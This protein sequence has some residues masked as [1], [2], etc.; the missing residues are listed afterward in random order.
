MEGRGVLCVSPRL[1]SV[2]CAWMRGSRFP[3]SQLCVSE[4]RPITP[5]LSTKINTTNRALSPR[6]T[7]A[8]YGGV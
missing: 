6:F 2:L 4:G 7:R 1:C 5:T 8:D 3:P